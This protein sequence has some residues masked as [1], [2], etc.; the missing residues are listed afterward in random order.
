MRI[1][2]YVFSRGPARQRATN[3]QDLERRG[4]WVNLYFLYQQGFLEG[5]EQVGGAR[6]TEC[7]G[8]ELAQDC[9]LCIGANMGLGPREGLHQGLETGDG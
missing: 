4:R 9:V 2:A 5:A 1:R 7:R 8:A 3:R 6:Q